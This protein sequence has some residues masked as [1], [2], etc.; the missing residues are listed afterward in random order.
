[1][2]S[3]T[4]LSS[5]L[6]YGAK[7]NTHL[8]AIS[9][10]DRDASPFLSP[11]G[12]FGLLVLYTLVYIVPLYGSPRTRP[13]P[14]LSRDDPRVIRARIRSALASTVSCSICTYFI[15]SNSH[16]SVESTPLHAMGYWPLGLRETAGSLLL[17]AILFAA[18]L[19]ETLLLDGLWVDWVTLRPLHDLWTTWTGWRNIAMGPLTEELLF[20]SASVPLFLLARMS[21][22]STV[23][24]T[25]IVFGLAHIHHFYEFRITHPEVPLAAAIA[26]SILQFSYTS[27]FGA[28]ATFVFLRTRS[29]LAVVLVHALCNSIGL[30][31]FSGSVRPYWVGGRG[32]SSP[33]SA[34]TWTVLYYL[35]LFGGAWGWWAGLMPLTASPMSTIEADTWSATSQA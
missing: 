7:F 13:S 31:R 26:R 34:H 24:L 33:A 11:G 14:T 28:Y 29:L 27:L 32:P 1:M 19:Y 4:V 15:L 30:P 18:P 22:G 8:D 10:P 5:I 21:L 6:G 17:T 35:L 23:F 3:L 2:S 25:P 16:G 12:A 9:S 20:R